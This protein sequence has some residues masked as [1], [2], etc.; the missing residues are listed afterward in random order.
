MQEPR[1]HFLEVELPWDA[2]PSRNTIIEAL[3]LW[4]S[5]RQPFQL[6]YHA[7]RRYIRLN[8]PHVDQDIRLQF[9]SYYRYYGGTQTDLV[10]GLHNQ[11][12]YRAAQLM[13]SEG[14]RAAIQYYRMP[15]GNFFGEEV[16]VYLPGTVSV[17]YP[18]FPSS[19]ACAA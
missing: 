18:V 3:G 19:G 2:Y 12:Y 6:F 4:S 14:Y 11:A 8:P 7:I 9:I 15:W 5:R 10:T 17:P 16:W 1:Q 13:F